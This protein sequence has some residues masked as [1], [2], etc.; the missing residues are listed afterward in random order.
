MHAI[1][2]ENYIHYYPEKFKIVVKFCY[3]TLWLINFNSIVIGNDY[4]ILNENSCF[5]N[6]FLLFFAYDID[7]IK[8]NFLKTNVTI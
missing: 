5:P 4:K 1:Y 3:I 8:L 2:N 6:S 7:L